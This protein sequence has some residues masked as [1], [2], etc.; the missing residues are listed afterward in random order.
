MVLNSKYKKDYSYS[1]IIPYD[2]LKFFN[3]YIFATRCDRPLKFQ[4]MNY[5]GLNSQTLKYQRFKGSVREK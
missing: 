1:L 3:P 5:V 4:T 2:Y